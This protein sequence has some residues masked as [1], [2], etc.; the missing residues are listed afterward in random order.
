MSG[1]A[2]E[3]PGLYA[4]SAAAPL[5]DSAAMHPEPMPSR[6][7]GSLSRLLLWI[8]AVAVCAGSLWRVANV[9]ADHLA[10]PFD[11][12]YETPN[13]RSIQLMQEGRYVYDTAL[14]EQAPWWLTPYTPL[15]HHLAAL[16]PASASNPF[17][18]GRLVA[19][20]CMLAAALALFAV[21][22][23]AV[24][25]ALL[26]FGAFF[27]VRPVTSNTAFLKNDTLALVFSAWGV[28]VL[29]RAR[30]RLPWQLVSAVLCGL[31]FC[32]KQSYGAAAAACVLWMF[33]TQPR[34]GLIYLGA[35][36]ATL[37]VAIAW[38]WSEGFA[39][40]VFVALLDPMLASQLAYQLRVGLSQPV[41]VVLVALGLGGLLR[42]VARR[43]WQPLICTPYPLYALT[44]VTV[45]LIILPKVG[46]SLNYYIEPTLAV[47]MALVSW[48]RVAWV[49]DG[50]DGARGRPLGA[51]AALA[52]TLAAGAELALAPRQDIAFT[53]PE[54][55]A[56]RSA[57]FA[58]MKAE[59]EAATKPDPRVLN[60][61]YAGF[62]YPP[63]AKLELDDPLLYF[64]LWDAGWLKPDPVVAAVR[65][66][67]FDAI[68]IP[69]GML[70]R[71]VTLPPP[72]EALLVAVRDRYAVG[73]EYGVMQVL[74]RRP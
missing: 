14:Y 21:G 13:L 65:G 12:A 73:L 61:F 19:M 41:V 53:W 64:L 52:V 71:Q 62:S 15:Y 47:L 44:T 23:R 60:L 67:E 63:F 58:R 31:A 48:G 57:G 46:S 34:R 39:F 69:T 22:G 27:L 68:L 54:N 74:V 2:T 70:E 59:V 20:G 24:P 5:L 32:A 66:A 7:P 50:P 10:A 25:V 35:G 33:F 36:V 6:A 11:L 16:F 3:T 51:A 72:P 28:F 9:S 38:A 26:A 30:G 4:Q 37:L 55:N 29:A 18:P 17:V 45:M 40:C 43:R 56:T 8:A 1:S 49:G 42:L